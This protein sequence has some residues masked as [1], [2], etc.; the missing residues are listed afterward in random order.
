VSATHTDEATGRAASEAGPAD[1][2]RLERQLRARDRTI[3]VLSAR[4]EGALASRGTAFHV[5]EENITLEGI[6][7]DRT[8]EAR[9][10]GDKLAGA[11]E[12]LRLTQSQLVQAQK[13]EAIGAL[14]AGVAHEINTPVQYVSDNVTFLRRAFDHLVAVSAAARGALHAAGASPESAELVELARVVKKARLDFLLPQVP[15]A[16]DQSTEG[17]QRI[18]SIVGAMKEFSHPSV[19]EKELV[20]LTHA[21][22][23]TLTVARSEWKYVARTE[24][25]FDLDLPPVLAHRNE[26]NQVILNLIVNAAHAIE[27]RAK[28]E[29]EAGTKNAD[30]RKGTIA[31]TTRKEGGWAVIEVADTG[32]GIPEAI[33]GR[34]FD[35]FFTTKPVGKGTGQGL[36]I[37]YNVIVE[38][39][40][41]TI[42][43]ASEVGKGTTFTIRLP[44]AE[45]TYPVAKAPSGAA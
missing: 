21:I 33:R 26:L 18:A 27:E 16:L 32:A 43:V 4:A 39:H 19:K 3:A 38:Q 25:F 42:S 35:P 31:L 36:A 45:A 11:L 17:L 12:E 9:E 13:L 2:E 8:R 14:A 22:S 6:V 40:R 41:G 44:M 28:H 29:E 24:I 34:I 5:F 7:A 1:V 20:D 10:Q 23:T 30:E 37:A 15:R